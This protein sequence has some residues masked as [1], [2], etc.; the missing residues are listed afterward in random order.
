MKLKELIDIANEAYEDDLI[1]QCVNPETGKPLP[2]GERD[3]GDP[4]AEFIAAELAET[5]EEGESD[6][7][8]INTAMD[9]LEI[10]DRQLQR[11]LNA[12]NARLDP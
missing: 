10:A 2:R 6:E 1:A 4:L 7:Y 3:V 8:Q 11:V 9:T 12:L 5:F